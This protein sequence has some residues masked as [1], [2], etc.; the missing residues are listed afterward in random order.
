MKLE[1]ALKKVN[2]PGSILTFRGIEY[3]FV[4][5]DY[6]LLL[7]ADATAVWNPTPI[8]LLSNDWGATDEH[9]QP[10]M[11]RSLDKTF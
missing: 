7:R 11:D 4:R 2:T 8:E 9:F 10:L 1:E 6:P 3:V 5:E